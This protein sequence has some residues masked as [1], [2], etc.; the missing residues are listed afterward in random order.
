MGETMTKAKRPHGQSLKRAA[1]VAKARL[2]W[3]SL[4]G[5]RTCD[6]LR[7]VARRCGLSVTAIQTYANKGIEPW[8]RT[9]AGDALAAR[10]A[11]IRNHLREHQCGRLEAAHRF[12]VSLHIVWTATRGHRIPG[13][14]DPLND[15]DKAEL[16]ELW[17]SG[18]TRRQLAARY[19]CAMRHVSRVNKL[20][21]GVRNGWPL[22]SSRLSSR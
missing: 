18:W 20:T 9:T 13:L 16:R 6:R 15:A 5:W 11:A 14:R 17:A 12:G 3:D 1:N 7:E 21:P 10:D 22:A 4:D 2:V 19:G 8:P